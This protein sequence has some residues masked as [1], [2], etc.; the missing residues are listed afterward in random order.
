[1]RVK[2]NTKTRIFI[3]AVL[4]I[5]AIF[6]TIAIMVKR[7]IPMV[8][9][10]RFHIG[11]IYDIREAFKAHSIPT[12]VNFDSYHGMG[13]AVNGMYPDITL[14]PF[15]FITNGLSFVNQVIAIKVLI[16]IATFLITYVS[17][18]KYGFTK[19]NS[20]YVAILYAFSGYSLYQFLYELQPGAII[21]YIF[22]FPLIFA[23]KDVLYT[24]K[25]D[26]KL[27]IK[28]SLLFGIALYS[29]LLSAVVIA[30]LIITLWIVRIILE[31]ELNYFSILNLFFV[32]ILTLLYAM[33][34]LYRVYVI[35][36]SEIAPPYGKGIVDS[37]N[38]I[39]V[40][41]NPQIYARVSLSFVALVLFIVSLHYF[42][43]DIEITRLLTAEM[44]VII[45][46]TNL[47]PWNILEKLP[48][49][50]MFQF[51]PWRFGI[52]LS[53]LPMLAFLYTR[54]NNKN[55]ILFVL[56]LISLIAVPGAL[57]QN[58]PIF[59]TS[60]CTFLNSKNNKG[61]N[62]N[63]NFGLITRDYL[64]AKTIGNS[65]ANKVPGF[66]EKQSLHPEM[67]GIS[68]NIKLKKTTQRYG[69]ISLYNQTSA[70]KGIYLIPVYYYPSLKYQLQING[71]GLYKI[72][73]SQHGFMQI[74]LDKYLHKNSKIVITYNNPKTYNV[75]LI[76]SIILYL[77]AFV[78]FRWIIE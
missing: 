51:T 28:L 23:I 30:C 11:R 70:E 22:T 31:K 68:Q 12:W 48:L 55:V 33:P 5:L 32:S 6:M 52:Y 47:I 77:I 57:K 56:A 8:W 67:K 61:N 15:V 24:Q 71:K 3:V 62:F 16:L 58:N 13:Q 66:V 65:T 35:S 73:Q 44:V 4:A 29:H 25:I 59:E 53:A 64:P 2:I 9:D 54:F 27:I 50:D 46:C 39:D 26:V 36:K 19:E 7:G 72:N 78:Y 74:K 63:H 10:T 42:R 14:W 45:L 21:I 40:F 18:V 49:I 1:M 38:L 20:F 43:K 75:L 17:L 41:T 37:E 34:V 76:V 60:Q 69:S